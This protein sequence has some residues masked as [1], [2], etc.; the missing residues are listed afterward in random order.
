MFRNR[1]TFYNYRQN[2]IRRPHNTF[3]ASSNNK[4]DT[5]INGEYC[6]CNLFNLLIQG[7]EIEHFFRQ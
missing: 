4:K 7:I 3:D 2:Y 6:L 1:F 5:R